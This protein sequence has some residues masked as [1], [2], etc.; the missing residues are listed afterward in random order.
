VGSTHQLIGAYDCTQH[1]NPMNQSSVKL[2]KGKDG[3]QDDTYKGPMEWLDKIKM[4]R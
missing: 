4:K 2:R 1:Y 3:D